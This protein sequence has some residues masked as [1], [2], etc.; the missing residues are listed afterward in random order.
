MYHNPNPFIDNPHT[1]QRLQSSLPGPSY[2]FSH[3]PS[4]LPRVSIPSDPFTSISPIN[5]PPT[6]TKVPGTGVLI[7]D[8]G[9]FPDLDLG[10]LS[11]STSS[12]L[13][14]RAS[15]EP[16]FDFSVGFDLEGEFGEE[17]VVFDGKG[18]F[19]CDKERAVPVW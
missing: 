2:S 14:E 11:P 7:L 19:D 6:C 12:V 9:L 17:V 3:F 16:S 4:R 15:R 10:I 13:S 8:F 5:A 18:T 1:L